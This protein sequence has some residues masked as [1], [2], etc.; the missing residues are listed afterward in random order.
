MKAL[1]PGIKAPKIELPLLGGGKFSLAESLSKGSVLL[2]FFK[3]SCPICQYALPFIDRLSKRVGKGLKVI[4]VSQDDAKS[5]EIFRK[6]YGVS[7][8]IALDELDK[9]PVSNAYGLT[10][11]PTFFLVSEDGKIEQT[12]VSW[13]KAELEDIDKAYRDGMNAASPLFPASEQVAD[14]RPG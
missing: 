12:I 3:I 14:F 9:Y 6:E 4:G 1:D 13:S 2:A 10:N 7:F 8:P 11:V 5:T